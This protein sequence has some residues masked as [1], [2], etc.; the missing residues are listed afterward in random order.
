MGI[1][2]FPLSAE[3]GV[4]AGW[5]HVPEGLG[6]RFLERSDAGV[7]LVVFLASS[8]SDPM[9]VYDFWVDTCL[10]DGEADSSLADV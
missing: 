8:F 4:P 6:F 10:D 2:R 3:T 5:T 7:T 1:C 9:D